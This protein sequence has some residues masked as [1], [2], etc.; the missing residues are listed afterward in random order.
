MK[1]AVRTLAATVA[2]ASLAGAALAAPQSDG[3][4]AAGA[5]QCHSRYGG[6]CYPGKP[7]LDVTASLVAAGGGPGHFSTAKAVT[8]MVGD[9]L[10]KAELAKL[11]KQYGKAK[12]DTWIKVND[13][14][15]ADALKI[16]TKAGVKLPKPD[17]SGKKLASTLVSAGLDKDNTYYV[18]FMLDKA[19]S[20]D[21][22]VQVMDD[23]DKQKGMGPAMDADYHRISNQAYYDLAQ[24][25][26]VKT[27]K[28]AHFH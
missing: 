25:L 27:V 7:A 19:L 2:V 9:K 13:F 16:A 24:A 8:A 23:I 18:E 11:S 10:V 15:V 26:G 5:M 4:M 1:T 3:K 17:L 14:A 20:H 28:L 21:I 12:V 6:P 22:H